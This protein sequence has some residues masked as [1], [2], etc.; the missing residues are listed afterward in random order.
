MVERVKST[1]SPCVQKCKLNNDICTGCLRT[2]SEII[3]WRDLDMTDR[4]TT[5]A[6]IQGQITTHN[7]PGCKTPTYCAM[8]DGKSAST[9]WCMSVPKTEDKPVIS[10][11][12]QCVCRKCLT[13]K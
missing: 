3:A 5:M 8:D 9:C 7:C 2:L 10:I 13:G 6:K 11:G 12:E 1:S 4:M